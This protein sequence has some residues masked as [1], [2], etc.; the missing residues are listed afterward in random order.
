MVVN[1]RRELQLLAGLDVP[2]RSLRC[3]PLPVDPVPAPA[4]RPAPADDVVV[5][6]FVFP[7]RGYEPTIDALPS[8]ATLLALGRPSE[9]HEGLPAELAARAE[10][11]GCR[12]QVTGFVPDQDLAARLWSAG[13]PIAPNRRVAASG[14]INTWIA[15]GRRPLIPDSP[16]SREIAAARPGTVTVYD[17]DDRAELAGL[18][19]AARADPE[20]TWLAPGTAVGPTSGEVAEH[21]RHHF[22]G[23]APETAITVGGHLVLP[24]N[25]WDL[26]ADVPARPAPTVSVVVPYYDQQHSLDLVLTALSRQTHPA[27]RLQ[28]VVADDG[29]PVP[30]GTGAASGLDVRVVRQP[31]DGFRAAAARNL[32]AATAEGEVLLFLDADTV[33]E[34]DYVARLAAGP[35]LAPDL[36]VVGRRRHGDLA[37][38]TTERLSAWLDGGPGPDELPAPG[39]LADAYADSGDL[40]R[41]DHRS[42]RHVISAVL[43]LHRDLWAE[44]GGFDP[45][46][47]GYG[48][49]DWELAHRAWCSGAVLRHVPEAVA[50]HDGPDWAGRAERG[51]GAQ[52]EQTLALAARLP[53]PE[54]RGGGSWERPAVVVR[55]GFADPVEVLATARAAFAGD[56]DAGVWILA[57]GGRRT[58]ELLA[59]PRIRAGVPA[60]AVLASAQA[61]L[62]LDGPARVTGLPDLLR[63]AAQAGPLRLPTGRLVPNRAAAR[64]RR[65]AGRLGVT[66]DRLAARLF[67]GCDRPDPVST[68]PVDLAHEF[69]YTYPAHRRP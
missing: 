59:D 32:G 40:L 24:G 14:S 62:D 55:L 12:L 27:S 23:C 5:L 47:R 18:I 49:E 4:H 29:S 36:L 37:D 53:D 54:A 60:P 41:A 38:W 3:I 31:D 16:Y 68:R 30:P 8:G 28:V 15:H 69:K 56:A 48:G 22:A 63:A 20:L 46:F 1:S 45:G 58:A 57:D 25:R 13:V 6:G 10:A 44:L 11:R 52:N 2:A 42:Y 21:Y 26:L 7:D 43:G 39:W 51:P 67:G 19:R 17:P 33:P 66:E 64:A 50:W 35:G 9:G 65:W 61:V 34:P